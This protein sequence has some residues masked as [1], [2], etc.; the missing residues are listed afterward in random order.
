MDSL[1][2]LRWLA[3]EELTRMMNE[4]MADAAHDAEVMRKH[5][6]LEKIS[7]CFQALIDEEVLAGVNHLATN[8][9]SRR[10]VTISDF[11]KLEAE[12]IELRREWE[13]YSVGM[14]CLLHG[15]EHPGFNRQ[16]TA[17]HIDVRLGRVDDWTRRNMALKRL[18]EK[19]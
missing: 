8:P 7:D 6:A 17:A 2:E 12:L 13:E 16:R 9:G 10:T 3:D 5:A 11:Q 18:P 15:K 1:I 4:E 14:D 19:K